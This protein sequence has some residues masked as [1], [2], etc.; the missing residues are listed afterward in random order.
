MRIVSGE[1]KDINDKFIQPN[2]GVMITVD[3]PFGCKPYHMNYVN[4]DS[5]PSIY[6]GY[7]DADY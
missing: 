2:S 3:V 5:E 6:I 1:Y 7:V 4:I